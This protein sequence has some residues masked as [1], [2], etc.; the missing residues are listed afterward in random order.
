MREAEWIQRYIASL[1][2]APGADGLRDDVAL[3]GNAAASAIVTTD[4]L[5]EG[6]HFLPSDPLYSV[7]QKLLRV[8]VS[9]IYAKGARPAEA[10]LSI[11]WPFDRPEEDFAELMAGIGDDL[12][13]FG[14]ALIGGDLVGTGGELVLNLVLTGTLQNGVLPRRSDARPGQSVWVSG[15][16]GHGG[17][18]LEASLRGGDPDAVARY[19]VPNLPTPQQVDAVSA[20]AVAAM[21]VSD[22]LLIDAQRMAEASGVAIELNIDLVPLAEPTTVIHDVLAQ[23]TAG[24]D[25]QILLTTSPEADLEGFFRIGI[26]LEG[27]GLRLSWAGEM[28]PLPKTLGYVH[29]E[30]ENRPRRIPLRG[31]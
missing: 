9:D 30:T 11:A 15:A 6:R 13:Q 21:D 16:I 17:R 12:N 26:V 8:S 5:V 27:R 20:Y 4:M 23:C 31:E 28:I 19:R 10:L 24:D 25:Y 1:V 18:G 22:G 29:G 3:L 2:V 14:V 7:G